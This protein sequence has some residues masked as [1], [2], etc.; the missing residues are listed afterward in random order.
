MKGQW[1][2]LSQGDWH[3]G[4][5]TVPMHEIKVVHEWGSPKPSE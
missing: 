4:M 2:L 3:E 1:D 5:T